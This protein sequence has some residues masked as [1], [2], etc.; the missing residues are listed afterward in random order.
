MENNRM[1]VLVACEFSG[2]VREAFKAKGHNAWSCD[3]LDTEI[4]GNHIK[5][6]VLKILNDGWNLLIGFPS[7]TYLSRAA[8]IVL[9]NPDRLIHTKKAFNF[10][11]E[12][13]NAKI[14]KICIEN[15]PGIYNMDCLEAMKEF[16]DNFFELAIVD[17]PYGIGDVTTSK[18]NKKRKTAHKTVTW[19]KEIPSSEYFEELYRIS[20]NQIIWGANYF[21]PHVPVPG[22]IVHYK[23][24]LQKLDEG[25]IKFCP[26]DIASQSFD[27]RIEYFEYR[28]YGNHQG[29]RVNW[30]NSGPDARIHPTQK[31]ISLYEWCLMKYA[32]KGDKIL[33]THLG[34]GSSAIAC[35]RLGYEIWAYE[36][37]K[38]YYDA[39]VKRVNLEKTKLKLF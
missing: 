33:D 7:C 26:C 11:M 1:K 16:P 8:G 3:L 6:D 23:K 21:H 19:N 31:P 18:G 24:P 20:I 39:S 25:K 30:D 36:I 28:W 22:R 29:C 13:W 10:I 15:P 4:P 17:P 35:H 5:G 34:S 27:K 38:D 12:L 14:D 32:K 2:I 37:D 9:Y